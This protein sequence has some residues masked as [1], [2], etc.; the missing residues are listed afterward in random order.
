MTEEESVRITATVNCWEDGYEEDYVYFYHA[1]VQ[2][3]DIS[4]W[5]FIDRIQCTGGGL[6]TLTTSYTLPKG[7]E[8][9]VRVSIRYVDSNDFTSNSG[10]C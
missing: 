4:N 3:A 5:N 2:E 6:Q 1:S 9:V 8:H 7:S 10:S